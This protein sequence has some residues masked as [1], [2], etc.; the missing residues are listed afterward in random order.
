[1]DAASDGAE[2]RPADTVVEALEDDLNT[3]KAIA[4]LH[5][6]RSRSGHKS[7]AGSLAFLGLSGGGYAAWRADHAPVLAVPAADVDRLLAHR[8]LARK[9]KNFAEADRIRAE[10]DAMG[11]AL[12]DAK[13][14]DTGELVTTWE[15]KR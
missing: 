5:A 12:K 11:I 4:E 10:L 1:V 2:E 15:V 3:P 14:P 9:A 6:L 7:L 8:I 13:D